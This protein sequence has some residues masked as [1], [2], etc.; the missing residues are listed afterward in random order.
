MQTSRNLT[1][2]TKDID[3][4]RSYLHI[5]D[6]KANLNTQQGMDTKDAVSSYYMMI[7]GICTCTTISCYYYCYNWFNYLANYI[8]DVNVRSSTMMDVFLQTFKIIHFNNWPPPS[9]DTSIITTM[10]AASKVS[11]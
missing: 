6:K 4:D 2:F 8:Y 3:K 5:L 10:V 7:A 1:A 11:L 9:I